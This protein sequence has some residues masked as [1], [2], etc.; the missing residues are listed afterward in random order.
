[1]S[2]NEDSGGF[3]NYLHIKA[4]TPLLYQGY[5]DGKEEETVLDK[6]KDWF[7]YKATRSVVRVVKSGAKKVGKVRDDIR[8]RYRF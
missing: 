2:E 3:S 5:F 8:R 7:K 4:P 1:M 6:M